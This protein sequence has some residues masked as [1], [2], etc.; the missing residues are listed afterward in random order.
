MPRSAERSLA[1]IT[2]PVAALLAAL[3]ALLM[4][5]NPRLGD[6][7]NRALPSET[8]RRVVLVGIDDAS[9]RDYGRIGTW[10]RELYG[11]ALGTLEQAGATAVGIDVLLTV[12]EGAYVGSG[13]HVFVQVIDHFLGLYVQF[14]SFT[15]LIVLSH[16]SGKELMR[17]PPR[18]GQ[19]I[20]A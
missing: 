13:L 15:R 2:A 18:S 7:L 8:D 19:Q 11:Q 9:L 3:L 4:P 16:P 5:A 6:A 20:L 10:P 12:D 14:N 17:C 1:L